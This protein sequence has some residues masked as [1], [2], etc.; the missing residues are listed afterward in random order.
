MITENL[1]TLKI[2]RLTKE[3]YARELVAGTLDPNAIYL[4]PEEEVDLSSYARIGAESDDDR[5]LTIYGTREFATRAAETVVGDANDTEDDNTVYGAKAY[6]AKILEDAEIALI[7]RQTDPDNADTIYGAKNFAVEYTDEKTSGLISTVNGVGPDANGNVEV[8]S[9]VQSDWNQTDDTQLD[10]IKNKP[11]LNSNYMILLDQVNGY[12]Y[13]IQM[14]NGNLVSFCK[15]VS[16][17]VTTEPNKLGY[18][19]GETIDLTGMVLS[20]ICQDGSS[21]PIEN[22]TYSPTVMAADTNH[23]DIIYEECGIVHTTTTNIALQTVAEML[24]DF[25]YTANAD[26]TYTLT[27]WK[28]T[29]NGVTRTELIVPDNDKI[30]V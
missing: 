14:M 25:E 20:A 23:V 7:G 22:Y 11:T 10:Y 27:E 3:Q 17:E 26:G 9:G 2:H 16:I 21:R 1:S 5:E 18:L 15:C 30:I 19:E 28:E 29:V 24:V 12:E 4:T 13:V 8:V 6:A